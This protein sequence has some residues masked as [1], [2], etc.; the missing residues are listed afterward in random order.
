MDS[1][2]SSP[3]KRRRTLRE[4]QETEGEMSIEAFLYRSD[5]FR[6]SSYRNPIPLPLKLDDPSP[7]LQLDGKEIGPLF[8]NLMAVLEDHGMD[9]KKTYLG[10]KNVS[11]PG[12]MN[13]KTPVLT[14]II[15]VMQS[16][17]IPMSTW[18]DARDGFRNFFSSNGFPHI[19]IEIYD[20]DKAFMPTTFPLKPDHDAIRAYETKRSQLLTCIKEELGKRW[21]VVSLFAFGMERNAAKPALVIFVNPGVVQDWNLLDHKLRLILKNP[22]ILIEFLPGNVEDTPGQTSSDSLP[23]FPEMGSNIGATGKSGS[24]TIG[25][26]II[27]ERGGTS[28]KGVL[29][30]HHVVKPIFGN[31]EILEAIDRYG[32]GNT[33]LAPNRTFQ[34]PAQDDLQA[35]RSSLENKIEEMEMEIREDQSKIDRFEMKGEPAPERLLKL[36]KFSNDRLHRVRQ[37]LNMAEKLPVQVGKVLYSSGEAMSNK[38]SIIDWAMVDY[39]NAQ[40]LQ[41]PLNQLPDIEHPDLRDNLASSYMIGEADYDVT[42]EAPRF[43]EGFGE[44]DMGRWYFKIGRTTGLTTGVCNGTKAEVQRAER[45]RW[46]EGG[47]KVLLDCTT[48]RELVILGKSNKASEG[49]AQYFSEVGDSGSFVFDKAGQVAGLMYGQLTGYLGPQDRNRIYVNAGLVTSMEEILASI[50]AKTGGE[51]RL[52]R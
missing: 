20:W 48:T 15:E 1:P 38:K 32:Y 37:A 4:S 30:N 26:H 14:L 8:P 25:G 7:E 43:A 47:N 31:Q 49:N 5:G 12:Y 40:S 2:P 44:I 39:S 6:S 29:T 16:S 41:V 42:R 10:M 27:L 50:K 28:Y 35:A 36:I 18:S 19:Q 34:Y 23:R 21:N 46:D 45:V 11:K 17:E 9:A 13:G 24:G 51:L 3:G 22:E 33:D 52:P